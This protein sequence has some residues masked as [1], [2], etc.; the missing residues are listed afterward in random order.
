MAVKKN[1]LAEKQEFTT[2]LSQWSN[3]LTG[4]ISRDYAS[5][6]VEF[7]EYSKSCA[8]A[9]VTTIF[10]LVKS[11]KSGITMQNLDT[12]NLRSIV[13]HCASLKLNANA[14]PRE[15]YFQ[16]RKNWHADT[17]SYTYAVEMGIEGSGN[18]A[19]LRNYGVDVEHVYPYWIVKEGDDFTYPRRK[20]IE[21]EPPEWE[22]KGLSQKAI[23]VVYPVKLKNG[24][25][26]YLIAERDSVKVNLLAHVRN[27]LMN[28]T[29]GICENR[30]K[31]TD[32][33]LDEIKKRKDAIYEALRKCETVDDMLN[34]EEARPYIS[35]AWLDTSESM[36]QR[37]M[38]NNAI[39]KF[40]KNYNPMASKANMEMDD[41]Y[42]Q[43]QLDIEENQNMIE[44]DP[45]AV[46]DNTQEVDVVEV[47]EENTKKKQTESQVDLPDFMKG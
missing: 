2:A 20:G 7:D 41:T 24:T 38:L 22:E 15:C 26:E 19:I 13:E 34:C 5:C 42:Q 4:L 16:L 3:E 43:V 10:N 28:E 27:N 39:K 45:D 8:M 12:S 46:E 44:Y 17:K 14:Y 33:Q 11:D 21:I 25:V 35:G 32:N 6:G 31:A 18:D 37:K 36:I 1:E 40:P 23:R 9:A 47:V 29:F 30:Y